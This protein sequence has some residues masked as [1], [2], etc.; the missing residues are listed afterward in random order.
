MSRPLSMTAPFPWR[1]APRTPPR[2]AAGS[3][4]GQRACEPGRILQQVWSVA[5]RS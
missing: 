5:L 2:Q 1:F 3:P 4:G